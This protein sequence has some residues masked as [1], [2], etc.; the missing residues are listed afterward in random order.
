L[1]TASSA[2]A[3]RCC[4]TAHTIRP[5]LQ[6][7]NTLSGEG[8]SLLCSS[9]GVYNIWALAGRLYSLSLPLTLLTWQ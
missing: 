2:P 9:G 8:L 7:R 5:Y 4:W 6:R 3:G 1:N